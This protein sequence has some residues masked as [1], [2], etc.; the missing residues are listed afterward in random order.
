MT[1]QILTTCA[2]FLLAVL[3]M[4]LMFDSQI[5]GRQNPD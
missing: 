1:A 2:G 3:W 5:R 4:D